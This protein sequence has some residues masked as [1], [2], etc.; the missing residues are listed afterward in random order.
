VLAAIRRIKPFNE[1]PAHILS[2]VLNDS[3][4][5][6]QQVVHVVAGDAS[7]EDQQFH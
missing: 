1:T 3:A 2:R 4:F 6:R 7:T 5:I